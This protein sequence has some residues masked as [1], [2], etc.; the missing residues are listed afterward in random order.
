MAAPLGP[1]VGSADKDTTNHAAC[2]ELLING[3]AL[4][5]DRL[6]HVDGQVVPD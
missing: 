4:S 3:M 1:W 6:S 5:G 2:L